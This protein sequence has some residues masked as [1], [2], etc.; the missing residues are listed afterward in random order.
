MGR[1][2]QPSLTTLT[3]SS[4]ESH[5]DLCYSRRSA[6]AGSIRAACETGWTAAMVVRTPVSVRMATISQGGKVKASV[7]QVDLQIPE[8]HVRNPG[9]SRIRDG[10]G[11][12][13]SVHAAGVILPRRR[14]QE[15]DRRCGDGR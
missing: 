12:E 10:P 9:T 6:L 2:R 7:R 11:E 4:S 8:H 15:R 3:L 5:N 1:A 14:A 13:Q